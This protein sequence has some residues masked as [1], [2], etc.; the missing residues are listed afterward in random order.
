MPLPMAR[1]WKHPKTGVYHLR[2][3]VPADLVK[4]VG[5]EIEKRSLGT[6]DPTEAKAL[7]FAATIEVEERWANLKKGNLIL[8][9]LHGHL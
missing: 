3:R 6:K 8:P 9:R 7:H 5:R 1:P 4:L 2:R